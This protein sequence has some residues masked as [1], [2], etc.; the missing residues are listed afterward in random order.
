MGLT[1]TDLKPE[2]ILLKLDS[3]KQI[4]DMNLHPI[5]VQRK[6]EMYDGE[7]VDDEDESSCFSENEA[8]DQNSNEQMQKGDRSNVH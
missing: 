4:I 1:H 6:K 7:R 3:K 8:D 2:N 5:H